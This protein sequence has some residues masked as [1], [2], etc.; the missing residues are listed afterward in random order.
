[1]KALNLFKALADSTRIRI[2]NLL[3]LHEFNVN[4][5]V[6]ILGMGQPRISRHLKILTD[7]GLLTYRRDGLWVFYSLNRNSMNH[8]QEFIAGLIADEPELKNDRENARLFLGERNR[9]AKNFFDS[10]AGDY[11]RLKKDLFRGM[12]LSD[13]LLENMEECSTAVDMGCG[14]GD[15]LQA[16]KSRAE[17]IIGVDNSPRMLE[18]AR[19]RFVNDGQRIELRLGELEHLPLRDEEADCAILNMVLHHLSAPAQALKEAYRI[20]KRNTR[21][22]LTDF[23]KHDQEDMRLRY[24]DRWLGFEKG[25][26]SGW[27]EECGFRIGDIQEVH[28]E[29]GLLVY[30][31]VAYKG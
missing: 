20:L 23:L 27:L 10:I 13:R 12:S 24:G 30:L 8:L 22:L 18:Q 25:Q 29:R 1:M 17:R 5:I 15:L 19:K 31:F 21:C 2:M 3:L 7:V 4:E 16:L 26:I 28:L 6:E 11:D 14:T 9:R